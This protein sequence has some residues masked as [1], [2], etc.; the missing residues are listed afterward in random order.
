MFEPEAEFVVDGA[1]DFAASLGEVL[2]AASRFVN[3]D[4]IGLFVDADAVKEFTGETTFANQP[5]GVDFVA[6]L[7]AVDGVAFVGGGFGLFVADVDIFEEGAGAG[8]FEGIGEFV[9]TDGGDDGTD[10]GGGKISKSVVGNVALDGVVEGAGHLAEVKLQ[11]D[12]DDEVAVFLGGV[13]EAA[14]VG[15]LKVVFG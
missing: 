3:K 1:D 10:A 11:R 8:L 14:A 7:A 5:A 9:G 15:E 6:I 4:E 12:R 13:E 2:I